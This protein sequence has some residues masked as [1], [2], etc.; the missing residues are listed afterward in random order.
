MASIC[1][2]DCCTACAQKDRC[3]GCIQTNGHP[4]GGS[5]A[6]AECVRQGGLD[7]LAQKKQALI[8]EVNALGIP[9]L[10]IS[11]LHLL[12]GSYVN[13]SYPMPNG[14]SVRF[15]DDRRVYWGNQ[16][17]IPGSERCY[18]LVLDDTML[19]VCSY[20]CQGAD[21]ALLLYRNKENT[22]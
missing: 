14:E 16:V 19:L 13:L 11:D 5:C 10:Q 8:Q 15:L 22:R 9:H 17:E 12:L 21:P 6:A 20:G 2:L 4:F 18:G 1:G 3:G 7:A